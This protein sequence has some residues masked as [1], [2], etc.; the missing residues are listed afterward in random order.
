MILHKTRFFITLTAII[1]QVSTLLHAQCNI[2]NFNLSKSE[3]NQTGQFF[4][5]VNFDYSGTGTTFRIIGN[6][7][8][9]GT[10]GYHELPL[11]IGPIVSNCDLIYDFT[12]RDTQNPSCFVFRGLGKVCCNEN[13]DISIRSATATECTGTS[14]TLGLDL[15]HNQSQDSRFNIY[16]NGIYF[17]QYRYT[18]L[19]LNIQSFQG[20]GIEI[21]NQVVVC[22]EGNTLCCDTIRL[23]NPCIC[24]I[25]ETQ[26]RVVPCDEENRI[27]SV[28]LNFRHNLTADSF[29]LGGNS[30]NYGKFA[31]KDL[32][33][34][35]HNLPMDN[36]KEYE[37]LIVDTNDAFCFGSYEFGVVDSC[38]FDC[39]IDADISGRIVCDPDGFYITLNITTQNPGFEGLLIDSGI[40]RDTLLSSSGTFSIG[41][42][43]ADCETL[44]KFEISDLEIPECKTSAVLNEVVCCPDTDCM[45]YNLSISEN[46]ENNVLERFDIYF[47]I[48]GN[49]SDS[50]LLS[51][52]GNYSGT[53]SY[54]DLPVTLDE[55][56]FNLPEVVFA[57]T[58]KD[59][60]Y[61]FFTDVYSFQCFQPLI[62]TIDNINLIPED[63]E[64]NQFYIQLSFESLNAGS[65]GFN[66]YVNDTLID[67]LQ[68]GRDVYYIG[69]LEGDCITRYRIRL[70]DNEFAACNKEVVLS[71]PICCPDCEIGIEADISVGLC[72][73]GKFDIELDFG[74]SGVSESF[75][76][77]INGNP[78][79][80]FN[81]DKLP[82]SIENINQSETYLLTITDSESDDC[83]SKKEFSGPEC[84]VSTNQIH[85]SEL[86]IMNGDQF[87]SLDFGVQ[88]SFYDCRVFDITGRM[89][90]S[91][92]SDERVLLLSSDYFTSGV[93]IIRIQIDGETYIRR[94]IK[95]RR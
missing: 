64:N 29:Q 1:F 46:C 14:Y 77:F 35:V 33:V 62:C 17:G 86:K 81:Y 60:T 72:S 28:K 76:V 58:D 3:C 30:T 84:T 68:Y 52:N 73:E 9:Y 88:P 45:I 49:V 8:N 37:F 94:F 89:L 55:V 2:S 50:F 57:I 44:Y 41:P 65:N 80:T 15:E 32:P 16:T 10:F 83:I 5:D 93:H 91:V 6:G 20:S 42:L 47:D 22:G 90:Y 34:T 66:V 79:G 19:P 7:I 53:F 39:I 61:C 21:F 67:S 43:P 54:S 38:R 11:R 12:V 13:C 24:T 95:I 63:C 36:N 70:Q 59:D 27:F 31:Y 85:D 26:G 18:D 48:S 69:P 51:I 56:L 40:F 82:V 25:Y 4:V 23:L 71:E 74:Y 75:I 87:I 92:F 78:A